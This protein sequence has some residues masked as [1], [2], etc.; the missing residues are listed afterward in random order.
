M[1][2][3]DRGDDVP[4]YDVREAEETAGAQ[5][6]RYAPASGAS[7]L[8]DRRDAG[9]PV[10]EFPVHLCP[11]CDI[12]LKGLTAR[13]CPQCNKPFT[14]A[15][16]QRRASDRTEEARQDF[17]VI[18]NRR[19]RFVAGVAMLAVGCLGP[20]AVRP[21]GVRVWV[22]STLEGTMLVTVLMYKVF[23][24]RTW[25]HAALVAGIFA[26][27]LGGLVLLVDAGAAR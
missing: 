18:R 3:I 14:L 16:A 11:W 5:E 21:T 19:I 7:P 22:V 6:F 15:D 12:N 13:R 26:L 17:G 23:F 24:Q 8:A 20:I 1:T 2:D 9:D 10:P 27:L 4:E 25:S